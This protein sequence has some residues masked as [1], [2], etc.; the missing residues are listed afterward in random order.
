MTTILRAWAN[1]TPIGRCDKRCYDAKGETCRCICDGRNHGAGEHL[2]RVHTHAA[3]QRIR[4]ELADGFDD[5]PDI[6]LHQSKW[7]SPQKTD[8]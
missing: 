2:A 6:V 3:I 8:S 4:E 5:Y 1:G 7:P